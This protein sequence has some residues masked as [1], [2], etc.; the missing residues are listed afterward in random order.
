[1]VSYIKKNPKKAGVLGVCDRTGFICNR[2]DLVKQMQ[3]A[4]NS[5]IW[6]GLLVYK[7]EVDPPQ[8]Q[9]KVPPVKAD[10]T[11]V[12]DPRPLQSSS[13]KFHTIHKSNA[14]VTRELENNNLQALEPPVNPGEPNA[15][16]RR[17]SY[18][19]IQAELNQVMWNTES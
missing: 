17:L 9:D 16:A 15:S 10:P 8:P 2:G 19:E 7:E 4:G 13:D 18:K 11:P 1:M 5:L 6:T 12:I 3:W 14:E